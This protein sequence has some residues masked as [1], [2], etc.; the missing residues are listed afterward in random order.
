GEICF[1]KNHAPECRLDT[2]ETIWRLIL[3][4][5]FNGD[6]AADR[7]RTHPRDARKF[8]LALDGKKTF[9]K[10]ALIK[11]NHTIGELWQAVR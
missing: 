5:P 4:S 11:T 1:G 3:D 2:I 9:P 8:L 7:C 6:R 10:N